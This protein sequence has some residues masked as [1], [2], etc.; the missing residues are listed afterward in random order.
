MCLL[1]NV[2]GTGTGIDIIKANVIHIKRY[3]LR[4]SSSDDENLLSYMTGNLDRG[5]TLI[6]FNPHRNLNE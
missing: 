5:L 3:V 2:G 1:R 4:V 6:K